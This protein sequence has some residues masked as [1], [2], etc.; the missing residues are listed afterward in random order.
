M[1]SKLELEK[2][3]NYSNTLPA[4][5]KKKKKKVTAVKRKGFLLRSA[6]TRVKSTY[7]GGVNCPFQLSEGRRKGRVPLQRKGGSSIRRWPVKT[8]RCGKSVAM[9]KGRGNSQE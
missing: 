2:I 7:E 4:F 9:G 1:C 3:S 6:I 5:Q 8:A